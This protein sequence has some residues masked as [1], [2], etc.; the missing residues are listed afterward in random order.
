[1]Q[2]LCSQI[3]PAE[4]VNILVTGDLLRTGVSNFDAFG[5]ERKVGITRDRRRRRS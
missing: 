4:D 3:G 1:L 2:I 5:D